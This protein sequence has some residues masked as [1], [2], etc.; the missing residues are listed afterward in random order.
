[1]TEIESALRDLEIS[2]ARFGLCL[3]ETHLR[4][5]R[6]Y[7]ERLML[8]NSRVALV[9]QTDPQ[10]IVC[11]HFV[12]SLFAALKCEGGD[13]IVDLGSGA[14]FPGLVAAIVR[15]EISV[16]LVESRRKKVSFL[17]DVI[18]AAKVENARAVEARIESLSNDEEYRYR[19][20]IA[21]SRAL[22]SLLEFLRLARPLLSDDGRAIAMKGPRYVEELAGLDTGTDGFVMPLVTHYNLP[23]ASDRYLLEFRRATSAA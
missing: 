19:H 12:D 14:G 13:R 10:Q 2:A 16:C 1:M 8:W 21:F 5:F 15:P 6:I 17:N 18:A 7:M 4:Q 11:K 22:S 3:G 20:T 9:S 23:D